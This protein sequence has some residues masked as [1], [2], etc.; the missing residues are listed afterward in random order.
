M[1]NSPE[2]IIDK[3]HGWISRNKP[4]SKMAFKAAWE[5]QQAKIQSLTEETEWRDIETAPHSEFVLIGFSDV[6]YVTYAWFNSDGQGKWHNANDDELKNPTHWK[7]LPKPP[8]P[9][10]DTKET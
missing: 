2:Q 3:W 7:P 4:V 6:Q 9:S 5:I 10:K 8:T 1:T